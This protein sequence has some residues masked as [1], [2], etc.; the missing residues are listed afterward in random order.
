MLNIANSYSNHSV[1]VDCMAGVMVHNH[2]MQSE[3]ANRPLRYPLIR[4]D[5]VIAV[6]CV[7][8][9]RFRYGKGDIRL[10]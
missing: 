4:S 1:Q 3:R 9:N 5:P 8:S 2:I 7:L 10:L 6:H